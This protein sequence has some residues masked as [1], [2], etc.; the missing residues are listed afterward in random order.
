MT[1]DE[2]K[3]ILHAYRP[4]GADASD[5]MFD[6]ALA[7]A[8]RDPEL[9]EWFARLQA[10]D[11]AIARKLGEVEVPA[12]L[13]GAILAG[14]RV[15]R[16]QP[17]KAWWRRNPLLAMAASLAML[18]AVGI[19]AFWSTTRADAS[20]ELPSF[21]TDYV[22]AGFFLAEH[23][24]D[25]GQLKMWLKGQNSPLP[26]E[27]PAGFKK[28]RGLGCKTI[29]YRGRN[30]SLICFGEGREYHLFVANRAD[31]PNLP[32]N[33]APQFVTRKGLCAATWSDG[34]HHYVVVTDDTMMALKQCLD[35]ESS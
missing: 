29:D 26:T 22:A 11:G 34:D 27:L 19:P 10:F 21:A 7:Q 12:E 31:F 1:N 4:N 17:T 3:F 15:S 30:I 20:A 16:P 33:A 23:D 8:R 28:L 14:A 25:V 35:C 9:A 13:R 18:L 5:P 24:A 32:A 2:A 6:A